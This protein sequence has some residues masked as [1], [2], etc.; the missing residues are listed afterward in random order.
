[1]QEDLRNKID[2]L[3]QFNSFAVDR[4]LKMLQLKE[5]IAMLEQQLAQRNVSMKGE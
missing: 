4:E 1:M 5:Q 3:E 2:D